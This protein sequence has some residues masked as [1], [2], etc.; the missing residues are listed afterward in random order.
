MID[1]QTLISLNENDLPALAETL[2][3]ADISMLVDILSEKDGEVRYRALRLL[4]FRSQSH[5]DVFAYWDVFV[6]KLGH[7]NSFLRNIGLILI[8]ANAKWADET[9]MA[10]CIDPYLARLRDEKP[11]TIR[12]CIQHLSS[13]VPYHEKL[14]PRIADALV[15]FDHR[16]VRETMRKLVLVDIIDILTLI[17]KQYHDDGIERTIRDALTGG[18]LDN[19]EKEAILLRIRDDRV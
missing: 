19:K 11:I 10:A 14:V 15:R 7:P 9:R 5:D 3:A 18:L 13:I 16:A 2:D 12:Q 6:G 17:R 8:A 1:R 4:A